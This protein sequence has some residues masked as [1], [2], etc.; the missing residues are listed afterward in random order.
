M[1]NLTVNF[2]SPQGTPSAL[3]VLIAMAA[4]AL[5][6]L[7]YVVDRSA[8]S[9]YFLPHIGSL[10]HNHKLWFGVLGDHIPELVHV[11]AFILLT[12]SVA[13]WP[14]RALPI[15]VLWLAIDSLFEIG[16]YPPVAVQIAAAI[17]R[18]FQDVPILENSAAYFLQG[19]FD[20]WDLLAIATGAAC[21]YLTMFALADRDHSHVAP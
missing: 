2:R 9:V 7:V 8:A 11:Y 15:C 14:V 1:K 16:Q 19:V 17:P 4:P 12:A 21:G 5:G 6:I 18:W 13:S 10:A 3:F 20:P